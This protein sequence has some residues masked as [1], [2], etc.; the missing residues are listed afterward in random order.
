MALPLTDQFRHEQWRRMIASAGPADLE[1]LRK[2]A[3]NL[4]DYAASHRGLALQLL[5]PTAKAPAAEA[6]GAM[7]LIGDQNS[8]S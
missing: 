8:S 4:L 1:G 5:D 6:T 7:P 2:L 3:L